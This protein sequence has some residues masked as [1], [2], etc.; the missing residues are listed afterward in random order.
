[1][2]TTGQTQRRLC[3]DGQQLCRN[4]RASH[5]T[6]LQLAPVKALNLNN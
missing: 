4:G 3:R 5:Q 1:M 6:F 2:R